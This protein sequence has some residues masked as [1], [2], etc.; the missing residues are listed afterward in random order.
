MIL[1]QVRCDFA[2]VI[3]D[4]KYPDLTKIAYSAHQE[5]NR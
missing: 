3:Y 5:K 2:M 4:V 1:Q